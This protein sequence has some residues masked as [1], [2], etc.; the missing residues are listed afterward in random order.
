MPQTI[1]QVGKK[2]KNWKQ[3]TDAK[4][5]LEKLASIKPEFL[6]E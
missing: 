1:L 6:K 3:F 2:K 4:I 5:C